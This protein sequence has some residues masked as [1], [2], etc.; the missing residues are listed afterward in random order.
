MHFFESS[1]IGRIL[2]R[3]NK[4]CIY[5]DYSKIQSFFILHITCLI[6]YQG[7][8]GHR[9]ENTRGV[10]HRNDEWIQL[11][12]CYRRHF[13]FNTIS[14]YFSRFH[15]NNLFRYSSKNVNLEFFMHF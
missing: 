15:L 5:L 8:R 7:Y 11:L 4:V 6:I 14:D 9:N 13:N 1:P 10:S 3:F 2:N 12:K